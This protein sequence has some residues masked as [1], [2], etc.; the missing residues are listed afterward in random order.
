MISFNY[1]VKKASQVDVSCKCHLSNIMPENTFYDSMGITRFFLRMEISTWKRW[2]QYYHCN[3][4]ERAETL[5]YNGLGQM[6]S[7]IFQ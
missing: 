2:M 5:S 1:G 6:E 3:N 4:N 7:D